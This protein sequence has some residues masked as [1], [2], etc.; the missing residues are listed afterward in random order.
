MR[1]VNYCSWTSVQI[2]FSLVYGALMVVGLIGNGGVLFAVSRNKRLRSARNIFLLNLILTDILLCV[3]AI[4]ITPWYALTKD[5]LFG[6]VM[7]RLMPLSNSCSVFVTRLVDF[8]K[9]EVVNSLFDVP[10]DVVTENRRMGKSQKSWPRQ[11]LI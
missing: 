1:I 2:A 7:C 8:F 4:P 11:C 10:F 5:W 9:F 3:T 6:A